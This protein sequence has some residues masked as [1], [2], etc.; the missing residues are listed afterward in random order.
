MRSLR[1]SRSRRCEGAL[2]ALDPRTGAV[3]AL[4]G[5]LDFRRSEFDRSM[6]ARRQAGSSF[7]PFVYA[8][9]LQRGMTPS[10]RVL[11]APTVFVEPGTLSVYQPENYGKKY[12]GLLTLREALEKSANIATVKVLDRAGF[13]PVIDLARELGLTTELQPFPSM[14]LGAFE[15]SLLR[16]D[17]RLRRVRQSGRPRRALPRRSG[18]RP[19]GERCSTKRSPRRGRSSRRRS[20]R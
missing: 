9:A 5:G 11:D 3:R 8:A 18:A 17:Q 16:D 20:R 2:V 19:R 4:V 13:R 10:D 15:V 12:Y 1:S 7:K 6:Q 14:A